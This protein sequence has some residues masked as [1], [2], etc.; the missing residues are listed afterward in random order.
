MGIKITAYEALCNLGL[1]IDEIYSRAI[2]GESFHFI[3]EKRNRT[4]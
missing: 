4:M 2:N 1:N 3:E